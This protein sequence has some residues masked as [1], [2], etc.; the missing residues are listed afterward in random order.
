MNHYHWNLI[1]I[2][3]PRFNSNTLNGIH[4]QLKWDAN[5]C[6][7][8]LKNAHNYG[9]QKKRMKIGYKYEIVRLGKNSYFSIDIHT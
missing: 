6:K 3:I 4:I 1:Q 7:M 9:V 2:R 5:W 8:Y